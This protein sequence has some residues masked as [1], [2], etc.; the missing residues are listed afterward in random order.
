MPY[1]IGNVPSYRRTIHTRMADRLDNRKLRRDGLDF[2]GK[3]PFSVQLREAMISD[4]IV[5]ASQAGGLC[6]SSDGAIIRD[7]YAE[8]LE[9]KGASCKKRYGARSEQRMDQ[10]SFHISVNRTNWKHL[11]L[12]CRPRDPSTPEGWTCKD[13]LARC[14][15]VLGYVSRERFEA[16][17]PRHSQGMVRVT[18][19]PWG[20][21][22]RNWL[23]ESITWVKLEDIT[24]EWWH[25]NVVV[26]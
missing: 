16:A 9:I 8:Y 21:N 4:V 2:A 19:T 13:E 10:Y 20:A 26:L 7:R 25:Y 6:G 23:G 17:L 18:V 12:V 14:G 15:M 11:F 1:L 24:R 5:D 22:S 3:V